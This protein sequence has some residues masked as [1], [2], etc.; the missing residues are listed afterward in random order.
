MVS[1]KAINGNQINAVKNTEQSF[2]VMAESLD[3]LA[4]DITNVGELN[5]AMINQK[6]SIDG[7]MQVLAS[8]IAQISAST[9]E[10]SASTEEQ[11]SMINEV[12]TVT[13]QFERL[14][15]KLLE[16]VSQYKAV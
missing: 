5:V 13:G 7:C 11:L 3:K 15:N 4:V 6:D 14:S 16:Q 10:I 1:A 8:G 2:N 9:Q 12:N